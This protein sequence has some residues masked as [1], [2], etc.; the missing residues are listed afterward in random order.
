MDRITLTP[1]KIIE[2]KIGSVLHGL[3]LSEESFNG[4]GEAYF[5]TLNYGII[6]GWKKHNRMILNLIVVIG[7]IK[8]V[9]YDENKN[10][11]Y[12]F[13]LSKKNHSRL[14]IKPGLWVAFK[15]LSTENMLLNIASIE[16][17]PNEVESIDLN[18]IK[19][20]DW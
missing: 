8:F 1:L 11:F 12:E 17:D 9:V 7:K 18:K 13:I 2:S 16:H 10:K 6:K 15:G 4:F 20:T 19:F 14:T 3:K 5:S